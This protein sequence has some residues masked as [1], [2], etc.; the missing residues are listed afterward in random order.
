[1]SLKFKLKSNEVPVTLE[2]D[3]G[4]PEEYVLREMDAASR[5][6]YVDSLSA[7]LKMDASGKPASLTKFDGMQAELLVHTLR[8]KDTN[9]SVRK[10]IIQ[11]W[12]AT[13]VSALFAEAQKLNLLNQKEEEVLGD[14][15][16]G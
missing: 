10:E 2:G 1:M 8:R 7:R 4:K 3:D 16:N 12:P 15:K 5:D 9:A 14:S 6:R 13:V 11:A